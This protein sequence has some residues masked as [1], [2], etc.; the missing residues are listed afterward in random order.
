M[1]VPFLPVIVGPTASG[2]SAVALAMA[3]DMGGEIVSADSRQVYRLIPIGTAQPTLHERDLVPHHLV[4]EISLSEDLPAGEY[5]G[6]ARDRIL[7]I[8]GRGKLPILVGGSGLHIRAI[9]DGLFDGPGADP[10]IRKELENLFKAEGIDPL[11]AE[12]ER[13]DPM[14]AGRI[15]RT[16]PRRVIRALEVYR[17]TGQPMSVLQSV[18]PPPPP[19][20][21]TQFGLLWPRQ[22]LYDRIDRRCVQMIEAG[23]LA[24]AESLRKDGF[25]SSLNA[26]NTVGYKEAF[27]FL[28]GKIGRDEF[29]RL[30][31]QNSRRYA[32]RQMTWFRADNRI[33]WVPARDPFDSGSIAA[34]IVKSFKE[35][36]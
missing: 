4:G 31:Q 14:T 17:L 35:T 15:D 26:L 5:A 32:K 22:E 9:I 36:P 16:K 11:M 19:F 34:Q 3:M 25:G 6:R 27:Q 30:F 29:V 12:L 18:P 7:E 21:A 8:Y 24:E 20:Q 28:S 13:V 1:V 2:K 33:N 10:G 23:L